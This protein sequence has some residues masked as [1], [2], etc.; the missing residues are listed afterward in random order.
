MERIEDLIAELLA[1]TADIERARERQCCAV[2]AIREA[3]Q[4]QDK[5]ATYQEAAE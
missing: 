1:A 5:P 2:E 3:W 4:D